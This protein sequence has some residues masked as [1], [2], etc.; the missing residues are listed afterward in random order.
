MAMP[1]ARSAETQMLVMESTPANDVNSHPVT[2]AAIRPMA[3]LGIQ[4]RAVRPPAIT[5][6]TKPASRPTTIQPTNVRSIGGVWHAV[7]AR[8]LPPQEGCAPQV[9]M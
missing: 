3:R 4:P 8:R 9:P 6:E 2:T 7:R 5:P 1:V